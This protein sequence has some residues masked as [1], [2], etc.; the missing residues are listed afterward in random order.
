[1]N[2]CIGSFAFVVLCS[3]VLRADVTVTTTT[4]IEGGLSA[5]M[6]G[7]TPKTVM[8]IKGM[9]ARSD[10]EV[11]GRTIASL[12][13]LTKKE[14][15]VLRPDDKTAHVIAG[16]MPEKPGAP[17][18]Q[19]PQVDGSFAPT[20]RSQTI[21]GLKCEEYAFSMTVA[22]SNMTS[23]QQMPPQ[24][25]EMLKDLQMLMK[26]STW[27]AKSAPGAAEYL[28]FQKAAIE[29]NLATILAGGVPGAPSNGMDRVMK[30]FTGAE[31]IPYLT[32]MNMTLEGAG[33]AADMMKQMGAM[34]IT[35]KV[36][37]ISTDP[38]AADLLVVPPDYKI[39]K[40]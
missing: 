18:A 28:A 12:V 6:A 27:V 1:M 29:A 23:G 16:V 33:A 24:A 13:D 8:H 39:I 7:S 37:A 19:L 10:V 22:M 36:T 9:Q 34:K 30:K 31:G 5:M 35:S 20:G 21:D 40:P 17:P 25:A 4:T 38:I 3:T 26:G 14:V 2:R 11:M 32:E 15:I